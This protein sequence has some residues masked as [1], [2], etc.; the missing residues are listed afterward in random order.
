MKI[1]VHSSVRY[2]KHK[3]FISS[4]AHQ[5]LGISATICH[6]WCSPFQTRTKTTCNRV[7]AK[8]INKKEASKRHLWKKGWKN[9]IDEDFE[10]NF[11]PQMIFLVGVWLSLWH[12]AVERCIHTVCTMT[13]SW[14]LTPAWC[15]WRCRR[16]VRSFATEKNHV[17]V[18]M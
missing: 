13:D 18:T 4:F 15:S 9:V 8:K 6:M 17:V 2:F 10:M 12:D 7:L 16:T 3:M 1:D 14:P 11:I 5:L